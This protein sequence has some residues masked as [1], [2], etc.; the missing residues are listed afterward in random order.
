MN[1]SEKHVKLHFIATSLEI[2]F[3]SY[4]QTYLPIQHTTLKLDPAPWKGGNRELGR[5]LT[6]LITQRMFDHY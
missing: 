5:T 2:L 4:P 6:I 1:F 3:K